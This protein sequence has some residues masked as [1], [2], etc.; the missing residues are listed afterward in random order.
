MKSHEAISQLLGAVPLESIASQI[1]AKASAVSQW[2]HGKT[3][4]PLPWL[5]KLVSEFH[6]GGEQEREQALAQLIVQQELESL[7]SPN[8]R[9]IDTWSSETRQLARSALES[10]LRDAQDLNRLAG[11]SENRTL[12]DFPNSFYPLTI[13]SGDKRETTGNRLNLADFGVNSASSAESRWLL[14]LG[15]SHDVE[16]FGDKVFLL[17]PFEQLQERFG[18]TNLLVIGSP[19]SNHLSRRLL[20]SKRPTGWHGRGVPLFRFNLMQFYI[21]EIEDFLRK[22]ERLNHQ[23]LVGVK[24]DPKTEDYV[25]F[26]CRFLFTGGIVDPTYA[27]RWIRAIEIPPGRDF[28]LV[29]LARNPFSKPGDPYV[30]ILAAGFHM[31]GTAHAL[32]M[33]AEPRNFETHPFGGVIRVE[34]DLSEPFAQRFDTSQA[35]W[36]DQSEYSIEQFYDGLKELKKSAPPSVHIDP[37]QIEETEQFLR[38]L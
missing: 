16:C 34:I 33:L 15:L 11:K 30:C 27:K 35:N 20:W 29:S 18:K 32:R 25:K 23:Q 8:K 26:L 31:L 2:R 19:G 9:H 36:D 6:P 13:V 21:D 22:I 14:R 24:G 28:G 5:A 4:C 10:V 17:E 38:S 12:C 37:G 3:S 1:G 7:D